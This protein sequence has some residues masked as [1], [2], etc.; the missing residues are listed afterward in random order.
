MT[1]LEHMEAGDEARFFD[2]PIGLGDKV[3]FFTGDFEFVIATVLR[4]TAIVWGN[5]YREHITLSLRRGDR[6]WRGIDASRCSLFEKYG[7]GD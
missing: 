7:S 3:T 6:V 5:P 2:Q 4:I 1:A